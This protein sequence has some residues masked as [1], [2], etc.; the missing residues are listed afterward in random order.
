VV[1]VTER[2]ALTRRRRYRIA[3]NSSPSGLGGSLLPVLETELDDFM[4]ERYEAAFREHLVR[5]AARGDLGDEIVDIGRWWRDVPA[6]ERHLPRR[7]LSVARPDGQ[8]RA[9]ACPC[10]TPFDPRSV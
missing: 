10:S 5:M 7:R 9:S 1:P 2:D 4:G 6:G 8:R 3:D